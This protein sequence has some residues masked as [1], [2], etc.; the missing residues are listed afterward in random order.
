MQEQ[1]K[2][3]VAAVPAKYGLNIKLDLCTIPRNEDFGTADSLRMVHDK[4]KVH[5]SSRI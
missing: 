1:F 3:E 5:I 2:A 4:I